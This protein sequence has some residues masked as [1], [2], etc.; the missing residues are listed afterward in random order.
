MS[1]LAGKGGPTLWF[2]LLFL[3]IIFFSPFHVSA[4]QDP[5]LVAASFIIEATVFD[6][7][8][9][10]EQQ[11]LEDDI[12]GYLVDKCREHYGFLRWGKKSTISD[13]SADAALELRL[14]EEVGVFGASVFLHFTVTIEN[15]PLEIPHIGR[16]QLYQAW[17]DLPTHDPERL[18]GDIRKM[19]DE[20]FLSEAFTRPLHTD[21]LKSIPL[22]AE[23]YVDSD[24]ERIILPLKWDNL[25]AGPESVLNVSF[26][27][28]VNEDKSPGNMNLSPEGS[29]LSDRWFGMVQCY[30]TLFRYPRVDA[31]S[32]HEAIP[33]ILLPEN[34]LKLHVFMNSY[35]QQRD[36]GTVGGTV[37]DP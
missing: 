23:I 4:Q 9:P 33:A 17:D 36:P 10:L 5:P 21:F 13:S 35:V 32:W 29:N 15:T 3:W 26:A 24:R 30:V 11:H 20:Q 7:I 27:A 22:V 1:C 25:N 19:L 12:S 2:G 14:I 8:G 31:V 18:A 6:D 28:G 34:I 16:L 37:Q